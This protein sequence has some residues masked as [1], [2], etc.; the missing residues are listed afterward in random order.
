MPEVSCVAPAMPQVVPPRS[1]TPVAQ[2]GGGRQPSPKLIS[3]VSH[4]P[5]HQSTQA[6]TRSWQRGI[7][8]DNLI[9]YK[10]DWQEH[11]DR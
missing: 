9:P 5:A 10:H 2:G 1:A 7:P 8:A 6:H 4:Y 3:G 11:V